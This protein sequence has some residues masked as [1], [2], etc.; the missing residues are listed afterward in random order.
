[1]LAALAV[2]ANNVVHGDALSEAMWGS[3]VPPSKANTI[4]TYVYRLRACLGPEDAARIVA[5]PPGYLLR[6]DAGELDLLRFEA[7]VKQ[8]RACAAVSDWASAAARLAEAEGLWRGTPLADIP[9]RILHDRYIDFLQSKRD[10]ATELR[11]EADI[12]GS[13]H[14]AV[15]AIPELRVLTAQ[16]PE[17]E[18]L[19]FLLMLALYRAGRQAEAL[20][21]FT[22]ARNFSVTEYGIDPGP[23]LA[24]LHTR[25]LTHD[26]AL[27]AERVDR[28]AIAR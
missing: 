3:H 15:G 18:R 9:T 26:P 13:R 7:L 21:V 6:V 1:L 2:N 22:R 23:E 5:Q 24:G 16:Y 25:I 12:R 4:R 14:G 27:L 8:G 19:C 28:P 17:Q 20:D 10:A 11:I